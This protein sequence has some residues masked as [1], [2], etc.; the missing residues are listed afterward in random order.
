MSAPI[1][2][3]IVDDEEA[4][5]RNFKALLEDRGHSVI[6]ALNGKE[7]LSLF[8]KHRPDIVFT[9]LRMPEMN[10][11]TLISNLKQLAPEIPT[12][13]VSG[14]GNIKDAI[15]AIHHG[16]WDY[17][18]KPLQET[19]EVEIVLQRTLE[20][21]RLRVENK[22]YVKDLEGAIIQKSKDIW[23][24]EIKFRTLIESSPLPII[25]IKD[26][27]INYVNNAAI[28]IYAFKNS[29]EMVGKLSEELFASGAERD[30]QKQLAEND[31]ALLV[32]G[33]KFE[34]KAM[35]KDFSTFPANIT[36]GS[37]TLAEGPAIII[38][39]E[40]ISERRKLEEQLRQAQKLETIGQLAGGVA[41]DF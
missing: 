17:L 5:L 33:I 11:L 25:L 29:K 28:R 1:K 10:G 21:A 39:T 41:H 13:V 16:A 22:K 36:V 24:S 26:N 19:G 8:A 12:V 9:D 40:D 6:S 31:F 37:I 4:I 32:N 35:R 3:L 38:F 30:L 2:I 15:E 34:T 14:T 20:H 23:Y 27:R 7:A 18:L